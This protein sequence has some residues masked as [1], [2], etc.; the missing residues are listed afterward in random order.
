MFLPL[1][2]SL[3][4]AFE[5]LRLL[6]RFRVVALL[7]LTVLPAYWLSVTGL[8]AQM[9]APGSDKPEKGNAPA[10]TVTN[11]AQVPQTPASNYP[12]IAPADMR[13]PAPAP[14]G[15]T[16]AAPA[17]PTESATAKPQQPASG[18]IHDAGD[19]HGPVRGQGA[20]PAAYDPTTQPSATTGL[21]EYARREES[22]ISILDNSSFSSGSAAP[23]IGNDES[24]GQLKGPGFDPSTM[25]VHVGMRIADFERFDTKNGTFRFVG[26]LI[27]EWDPAKLP[28]EHRL[29][30]SVRPPATGSVLVPKWKHWEPSLIMVNI[31]ANLTMS[32][33]VYFLKSD[34]HVRAEVRFSAPSVAVRMDFSHF[35][36]D[37]QWLTMQI[38]PDSNNVLPVRLVPLEKES[39]LGPDV[40]LSEWEIKEMTS[41]NVMGN[42]VDFCVE[43]KR[44]WAY[45]VFNIFLP[46][47]VIAST[48]YATM[49]I[50]RNNLPAACSLVGITIA[51]M[52]LLKLTVSA[53]IARMESLTYL[54]AIAVFHLV[55][56][57]S[58]A[59]LNIIISRYWKGIPD[60]TDESPAYWPR[61]VFPFAYL[62]GIIMISLF[63][64]IF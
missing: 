3:S 53:E 24:K 58:A 17:S 25:V 11:S 16:N 35:P 15:P 38:A 12:T 62:A 57:A 29:P 63:F 33:P 19:T 10:G 43:V 7:I 50:P 47:F 5:L 59:C 45:Y 46:M 64:H 30:I 40:W 13:P 49:W 32:T 6:P 21:R 48:S 61:V 37:T 44:F 26:T 55:T 14:S 60:P 2:F 23:G 41:Y 31:L 18:H 22:H 51:S 1:R 54:D 56:A 28:A 42:R 52:F 4:A 39:V 8:H 9:K 34:G 20:G 36:F 27:A